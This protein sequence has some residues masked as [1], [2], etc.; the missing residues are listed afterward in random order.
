MPASGLAFGLNATLAVA[1]FPWNVTFFTSTSMDFRS[2]PVFLFKWSTMP[3]RTASLLSGAR[4]QATTAIPSSNGMTSLDVTP[5][6]YRRM[7]KT[8]VVFALALPLTAQ[9]VIPAGTELFVRLKT[10]VSSNESKVDQPV[11]AVMIT[12]VLDQQSKMLIPS[13]VAIK[14]TIAATKP[15]IKP[16]E[17]A[18]Y[19][20]YLLTSAP[21]TRRPSSQRSTMRANL[22]MRRDRSSGSSLPRLSPRAR[23]RESARSSKERHSRRHP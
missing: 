14:G 6:L 3:S 1:R 12:P 5:A 16:D 9:T 19:P 22:W 7:S 17:R 15:A 10:I 8:L 2:K 4:L 18:S 23:I 13:G 20:C 21:L 11:E